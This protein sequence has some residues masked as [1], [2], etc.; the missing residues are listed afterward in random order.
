M[1]LQRLGGTDPIVDGAIMIELAELTRLVDAP[2]FI[3]IMQALSVVSKAFVGD[4]M[5]QAVCLS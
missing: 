1:L 3:D 4:Q 5:G 2:T